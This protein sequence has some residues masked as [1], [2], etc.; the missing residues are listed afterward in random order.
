MGEFLSSVR[1]AAAKAFGKKN[2]GEEGTD[3]QDL[4][5]E[6]GAHEVES[7]GFDPKKASDSAER[8]GMRK[9]DPKDEYKQPGSTPVATE[10]HDQVS[11]PAVDMDELRK[12]A[13][14]VAEETEEA[15]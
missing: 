13:Q 3:I 7:A 14:E 8:K 15:A 10:R 1:E 2:K 9:V 5:P 4:H 11:M 6:V 12:R